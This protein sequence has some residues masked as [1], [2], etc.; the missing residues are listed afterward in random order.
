VL[1]RLLDVEVP[2]VWGAMMRLRRRRLV[3]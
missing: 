2:K 3:T 1:A